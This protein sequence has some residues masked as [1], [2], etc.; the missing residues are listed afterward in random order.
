[1]TLAEA[2]PI[3]SASLELGRAMLNSDWR[4]ARPWRA[5]MA[6]PLTVALLGAAK[7]ADVASTSTPSATPSPATPPTYWQVTQTGDK[8]Q[9]MP[10]SKF[11]MYKQ[12][13]PEMM[14]VAKAFND[15]GLQECTHQVAKSADGTPVSEMSCKMKLSE[16]FIMHSLLKTWGTPHD[17]HTRMETRS[18]GL[19]PDFDKPHFTETRMVYI[20]EC[21]PNVK[22]GQY[23]TPDGEIYDPM[24]SLFKPPTEAEIAAD[25]VRL[26]AI[27]PPPIVVTPE[28][29]RVVEGRFEVVCS[30]SRKWGRLKVAGEMFSFGAPNQRWRA[31]PEI[32]VSALGEHLL[33]WHVDT[34]D[35]AVDEFDTEPNYTV[36]L[37]RDYVFTP[38]IAQHD[39]VTAH[40]SPSMSS[41]A[42]A[43]DFARKAADDRG[44]TSCDLQSCFT[45][46]DEGERFFKA[47]DR[48][49][50]KGGDM[51]I[52]AVDAEGPVT[53]RYSLKGLGG[54]IKRLG[55][56][57][58]PVARDCCAQIERPATP[59]PN[60]R[61]AP[62]GEPKRRLRLAQSVTRARQ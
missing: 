29:K 33:I 28:S 25:K 57:P 52:S 55:A 47:F 19:G 8:R 14:A 17:L 58:T 12:L 31:R 35:L 13:P 26:A 24:N 46:D 38:P 3:V 1:M 62:C 34:A 54:I 49:A 4:N 39:S 43:R 32:G 7:P 5:L 41:K 2:R 21:P 18:E 16:T 42:R 60:G 10:D 20:G 30:S 56:C 59:L 11:C 61:P 22:P 6:A 36:R 45:S 15:A 44:E 37:G 27:V 48:V 50:A 23:L 53:V 9:D 51:T 40:G